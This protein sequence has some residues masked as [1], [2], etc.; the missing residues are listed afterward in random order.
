MAVID[1]T[2]VAKV[3]EDIAQSLMQTAEAARLLGANVILTGISRQSA[4][5]LASVGITSSQ[6]TAVHDLQR[7]LEE[8]NV[9]LG[10]EVITR[11]ELTELR[12][13]LREATRELQE[14]RDA[15]ASETGSQ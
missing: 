11:R 4:Q 1:I 3:D 5:A 8:A 2:G 9:L 6:M 10:L 14:I 13:A 15:E 7:G 12:A